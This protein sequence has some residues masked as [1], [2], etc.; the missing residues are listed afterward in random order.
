M[1]ENFVTEYGQNVANFSKF[2]KT[3]LSKTKKVYFSPQNRVA[4]GN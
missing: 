3:V 1:F 2:H 4:T